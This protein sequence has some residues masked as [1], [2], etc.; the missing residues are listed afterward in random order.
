MSDSIMQ[1]APDGSYDLD[2]AAAPQQP[3]ELVDAPENPSPSAPSTPPRTQQRRVED[4]T[5]SAS[6][7]GRELARDD[8]SEIVP[9]GG[10]VASYD[11]EKLA[12]EIATRDAEGALSSA[13]V[14]DSP[15]FRARLAPRASGVS[16]R[17]SWM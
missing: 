15:A 7:L 11:A 2:E 17:A 3:W 9:L 6:S 14:A 10:N 1:P 12:F 8:D 5:A 13:F 4:V 16:A